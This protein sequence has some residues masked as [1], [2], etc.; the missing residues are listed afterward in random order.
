MQIADAVTVQEE[1]EGEGGEMRICVCVHA[2]STFIV[3]VDTDGCIDM[4]VSAAAATRTQ[5][6]N[7]AAV[8]T[9]SASTFKRRILPQ[10]HD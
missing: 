5:A 9:R 2:M 1:R 10:Q 6:H 3:V 8:T 4:R 7:R